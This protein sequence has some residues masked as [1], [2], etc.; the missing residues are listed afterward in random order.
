MAIYKASQLPAYVDKG[1]ASW[2]LH[3]EECN[4]TLKDGKLSGEWAIWDESQQ[5]WTGEAMDRAAVLNV[6]TKSKIILPIA[7]GVMKVA[8]LVAAG[9]IVLA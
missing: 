3:D 8:D 2:T 9:K 7:R 5:D 4:I 1:E 6:V